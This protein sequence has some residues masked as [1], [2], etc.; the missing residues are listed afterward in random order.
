LAPR[1]TSHFI[2]SQTYIAN[3]VKPYVALAMASKVKLNVQSFPR[4]PRLEKTARHLQVVYKG[5]TIADTKE[6]YWAL[7]THHPP[8]RSHAKLVNG[9]THLLS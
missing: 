1:N 3:L 6:A 2:I 7:E 9:F 5:Q 8:S 4:P